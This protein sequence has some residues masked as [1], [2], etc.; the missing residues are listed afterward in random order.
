MQHLEYLPCLESL[1]LSENQIRE[2]DTSVQIRSLRNL[3]IS[4]NRLSHFEASFLP[5]IRLL[6]LDN[7]YLTTVSGL[8]ACPGIEIFSIREQFSGQSPELGACL[9]IDIS[10][11][12]DTRK[13]FLSSNR[14][15]SRT[16]TPAVPMLALQ[17]LDIASCGVRMLPD[18][19]GRTFPNLRVLN[20]N[21]NSISDLRS[22]A[23]MKGLNRLSVAGNRISRLRMLCQT[24]AGIGRSSR[25][26]YSSLKTIDLRNNPLT[27]GF[28]PPPVSGSG[29]A[30]THLK[31]LED[32]LQKTR[33]RQTRIEQ[34]TDLL[35]VTF[36]RTID[37]AIV[38]FQSST[39]SYE[40]TTNVEID[41]PYTLPLADADADQKFRSRL[42]KSTKS[43]RMTLELMI[44]AGTGGS[45]RVL[46]G[47]ELKPV[48]E[49]DKD[50]VDRLWN[51]LE[52]LG[53]LTR[54][55]FLKSA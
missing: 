24:M 28:Y 44:Y 31:M 38:G 55:E 25:H 23:N 49:H 40:R 3:K 36:G 10:Q 11:L 7:N 48:L 51:K 39:N 4:S 46:D 14:L 5:R 43:R 30:D 33:Q 34:G 20:L 13:I 35:P 52:H 12:H 50:E 2:L 53:V 45:V 16:L 54:K 9:D 27:V 17:L 8:E 22:L 1:D 21:F 19:F 18:H 37:N 47:L 15:S 26:D 32:K 6:Y 42:D 29:R 41:D